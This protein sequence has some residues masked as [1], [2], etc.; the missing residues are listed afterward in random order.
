MLKGHNTD[1]IN[2]EKNRNNYLS[3]LGSESFNPIKKLGSKYFLNDEKETKNNNMK[4]MRKKNF[5]LT[6]YSNKISMNLKNIFNTNTNINESSYINNNLNNFLFSNNT[7]LVDDL[8]ENEIFRMKKNVFND[9]NLIQLKKKVSALK[10]SIESKYF[11]NKAKHKYNDSQIIK[12]QS[13]G[14]DT[15]LNQT[16]KTYNNLNDKTNISNKKKKKSIKNNIQNEINPNDI[17]RKIT[18]KVNLFDSFDD[19]EYLYE[20]IDFYIPPNSLFIKIFDILIIVSSLIYFILIPYFLSTNFSISKQNRLFTIIF[21]F[22][23]VIYIL[24]IINSGFSLF[25]FFSL[26]GKERY[27]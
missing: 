14:D 12:L 17:N 25:F 16:E 1:K 5:N 23:D 6:Y 27:F 10:K 24:E 8:S 13:M 9:M 22:I 11:N 18:R 26:F 4:N 20:E 2:K 21:M 15:D 19:E 3:S 7:S